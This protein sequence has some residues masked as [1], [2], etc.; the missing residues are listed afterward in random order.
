M[1]KEAGNEDEKIAK[2]MLKLMK[3]N[4]TTVTGSAGCWPE[5]PNRLKDL[6]QD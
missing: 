2:K 6:G 5:Q 3:G 1:L 4:I